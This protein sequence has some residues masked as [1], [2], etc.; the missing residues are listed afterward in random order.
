M[1]IGK[2]VCTP[3]RQWAP[4]VSLFSGIGGLDLGI[5]D[6]GGD[7]VVAVE[8]DP[9][10]VSTLQLNQRF[11]PSLRSIIPK[12]IEELSTDQIL[13]A[14]SVQRGQLALI[15]AGPPCQPFSKSG[16]WLEDKRR[17]LSDPRAT[18]LREFLRVLRR[19]RPEGFILENVASL[20]HPAH[21][22]MFEWLLEAVKSAGYAVGW[23]LVHAVEYGIPQT[24]SR[25]FVLGLRGK[26]PP[27][28]P[29]PTHWWPSRSLRSFSNLKAPETA[30]RWIAHL[31]TDDLFEQEEV[32]RGKWERHLLEIKPGWNYKFHTGWAGHPRPTFEVETKY[33]TFLLKLSPFRPSWTIQATPGPWTGPF[34]WTGRRLRIPELALLQTFPES[35]RL[36]GD[37]RSK[38]RQV[39]NAVPPVLA[40]KI[41]RGLLDEMLGV[42]RRR[43]RLRYRLGDGYPFRL[44]SVR[45]RGP[46]W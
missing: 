26:H 27:Q 21:R 33:W 13:E 14:G 34:H 32:V 46:R 10:C 3:P 6:A 40:S 5:E 1:H 35:F 25:V 39:G 45:H 41:A 31:D 9:D 17:G 11:L 15:V 43:R 28:F 16:Y 22:A 4:V 24:R 44:G 38:V 36:A 30:G 2:Q 29:D 12:P 42:R 37:R 18:L 19:A 8:P 20:I 7:I 23:R